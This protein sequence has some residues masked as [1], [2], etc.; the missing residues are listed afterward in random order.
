MGSVTKHVVHHQPL[1]FYYL[2][3]LL[4]S[5]NQIPV[6]TVDQHEVHHQHLC[7]VAFFRLDGSEIRVALFKIPPTLVRHAAES[8]M[9]GKHAPRRRF[10]GGRVRRR[11]L[12][13]LHIECEPVKSTVAIRVAAIRLPVAKLAIRREDCSVGKVKRAF[14]A[15][16]KKGQ[17]I[18]QKPKPGAKRQPGSK[19]KLKVSKGDTLYLT[20]TPYG[21]AL[22]PYDPS[23][24]QQLELG[25]EFMREYRETFRALAK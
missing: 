7:E 5:R 13:A 1:D 11:W 2:S 9:I 14:S 15:K 6:V 24:E 20:D 19:V 8:D 23:F 10:H 25:R 22:T 16:V 12:H 4:T 21:I 3:D 18:S 17:V